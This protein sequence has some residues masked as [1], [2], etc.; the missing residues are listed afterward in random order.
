MRHSFRLPEPGSPEVVVEN[1]QLIGLKVFADGERLPRLRQRGRPTWQV[2]MADGTTHRLGFS[3]TMTGLRA[4]V[5]DERV[6]ELERR[7]APWELILAVL[8]IGLVGI[9][10]AIGGAAGA[11]GVVVNLSVAR[12]PWPVA[13][14]VVASLG[15]LAAA[16]VAWYLVALLLIA[17]PH[18][19][20]DA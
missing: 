3:G 5:D 1:S 7:L 13:L 11:I 14:R 2:T 12:R 18:V 15:V 20:V 9:G 16:A 10:G 19:V 4:I 8:P 17:A 6:I